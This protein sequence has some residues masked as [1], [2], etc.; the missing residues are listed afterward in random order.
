MGESSTNFGKT[1]SH[2]HE[3]KPF[4]GVKKIARVAPPKRLV[5]N[6]GLKAKKQALEEGL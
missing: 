1:D 3:I 4:R 5:R 6:R 2:F